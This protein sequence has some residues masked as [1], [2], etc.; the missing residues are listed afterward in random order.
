MEIRKV[1]ITGGSSFVITIPKEWAKANNLKKNDPLGLMTQ[2]D[3][4]LL[5]TSKI[6]GDEKLKVKELEVQDPIVPSHLTR[7]LIGAYIAG[8]NIIVVKAKRA[9][10]PAVR[11]IVREYT[12]MTIGQEIVEETP[13]TIT[14]KDLLNPAEMP[15][16]KTIRRMY[17]IVKSMHEDVMAALLKR[18]TTLVEEVKARDNEV[19][20]LHWLTARQY[21]LLLR[22]VAL[23]EKIGV[24]IDEATTYYLTSRIMER[25]ADHGVRI[26]KYVNNLIKKKVSPRTVDRINRASALSVEI[27]NQSVDSL[28][29]KDL[30]AANENIT[31]ADRLEGLCDDLN[32][33][34]QSYKGIASLSVSSIA[35][36]IRRMGEYSVNISENVI[37]HLVGEQK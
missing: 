30:R 27:F 24:T 18:S 7:L 3:G 37:N 6:T 32:S 19:D 11:S 36:S 10:A 20:R 33:V 34:A 4:T 26:G 15:L 25:I 1:Q 28:F 13:A 5:V 29:R 2:P 8:F 17:I 16:E 22:N 14:V 21:N 12:H 31:K 23:T 35:G 9:S